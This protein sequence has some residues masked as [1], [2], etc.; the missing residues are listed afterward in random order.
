MCE[1]L[2]NVK[3]KTHSDNPFS[4]FD[5]QLIWCKTLLGEHKRLYIEGLVKVIEFFYVVE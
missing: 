5:V 1:Y 4:C 3:Q 2:F